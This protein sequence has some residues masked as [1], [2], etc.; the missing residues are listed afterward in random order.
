M[1]LGVVTLIVGLGIAIG[2]TRTEMIMNP[3]CS[4]LP[5]KGSLNYSSC[6]YVSMTVCPYGG[7]GAIVAIVGVIVALVGLIVFFLR[8]DEYA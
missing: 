4:Y 7:V 6:Y 3:N 5:M 8:S 2:T 1:A